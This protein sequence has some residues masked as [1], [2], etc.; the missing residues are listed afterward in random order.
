[1]TDFLLLEELQ[2]MIK[3]IPKP[4]L[5]FRKG[6]TA[7]GFFRP[8]MSLADYTKAQMF[9]GAGVITPV[10]VRFSAMLGDYGTA[11]TVRN[12][13]KLEIRFL[14]EQ[15]AY[16]MICHS[17]PV[18]FINDKNKLC[19]MFKI[20]CQKR[21]F[22]GINNK[23]FW[24]F[25]TD[26]PEAVNAAVHLYSHEG[27]SDNYTNIKLYS[28]NTAIWTNSIGT[29][30]LVRYKWLPIREPEIEKRAGNILNRNEAEFIAGFDP[31]R[32]HDE[33]ATRIEYGR[34]PVF[35]LYIQMMDL[36]HITGREALDYT[37]I[38]NENKIP[39]MSAGIMLL[40]KAEYETEGSQEELLFSPGN[41]V[42]GISLCR[43]ELSDIIEYMHRAE[44]MERGTYL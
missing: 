16:D 44:A 7:Q 11:D 3:E 39:F 34:Y 12:I 5:L 28:V 30:F 18:Q 40:D 14:S 13:K 4:R 43:N 6:I 27:L 31:H 32:A 2:R 26:N 21:W 1:M 19:D 22:D 36:R 42:G 38:W 25:V 41:T 20:F 17:L 24:Q 15:G 23:S 8:Y 35:E 37:L 33:L 9:S 29:E 10:K